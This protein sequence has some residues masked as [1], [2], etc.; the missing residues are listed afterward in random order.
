MRAYL[1][2]LRTRN[3]QRR[4]KERGATAVEY[5]LMVGLI[6]IGIIGSV[7]ALRDKTNDTFAAVEA[8]LGEFTAPTSAAAGSTFS[9]TYTGTTASV[10]DW[11]GQFLVTTPSNNAYVGSWK[12]LNDTTVPP[13]SPVL[14]P[15]KITLTAPTTPG[16]Y[17]I[18]ILAANG[19]T[20]ITKHK[21][22]I[23]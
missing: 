21:I 7:S 13:G 11:A 6:A 4:T 14:G 2:F 1:H 22:K 10:T 20:T 23:T 15:K 5:A 16:T 12:Y 19:F 8:A 3:A 9:F 17:E 18:R